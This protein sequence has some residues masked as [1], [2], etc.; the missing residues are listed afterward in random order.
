MDTLFLVAFFSSVFIITMILAAIL[1]WALYRV[2]DIR[3][4]PQRYFK[5]DKE[6][7]KKW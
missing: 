2:F 5:A 3:I 6:F 1:D 4:F 7:W